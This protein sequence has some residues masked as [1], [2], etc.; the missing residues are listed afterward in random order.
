MLVDDHEQP[1]NTPCAQSDHLDCKT[2]NNN[3]A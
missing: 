2:T 3:K 1:K